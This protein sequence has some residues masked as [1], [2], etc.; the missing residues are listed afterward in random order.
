MG[1]FTSRLDDTPI[2][3]RKPI[4]IDKDNF[5]EVLKAQDIRFQTG[6]ANKLSGDPNAQLNVNL[7]FKSMKDF[8]PDAIIAKVP[9]LAKHMELRDASRR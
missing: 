8:E 4:N 9:E 2:E 3:D 6:V 5:D 7:D 1:D